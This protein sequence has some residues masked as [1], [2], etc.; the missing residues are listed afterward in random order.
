[1]GVFASRVAR[2][3]MKVGLGTV[4][5]VRKLSDTESSESIPSSPRRGVRHALVRIPTWVLIVSLVIAIPLVASGVLAVADYV[6]EHT[7]VTVD[8]VSWAVNVSG[9]TEYSISCGPGY[10]S[11]PYHVKPGSEYSTSLVISPF[12]AG[13]SV[14]L[15]VPPP[16]QLVAPAPG[17]WSPVGSDGLV[18]PVTLQLPGSPGEYSLTGTIS[19]R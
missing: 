8:A 9:T 18:I 12:F 6:V 14:S 5:G 15:S 13:K 10:V 19:T 17:V 11:C 1:M 7:T 3:E 4:T 16:F 2:D